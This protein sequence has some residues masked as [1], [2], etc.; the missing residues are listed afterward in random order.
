MRINTF[1][2]NRQLGQ[3]FLH[4][5]L[6]V[7]T[8]LA[9]IQ[10]RGT[11]HEIRH[12]QTSLN[13]SKSTVPMKRGANVDSRFG[14][15][16]KKD[17]LPR[18]QHIVKYHQRIHFI[19]AITQRIILDRPTT[20]EPGAAD[21]SNAWRPQIANKPNGII[22][23]RIVTPVGNRWLGKRLISVRGGGFIFGTTHHDTSISF[24]NHVQQH[25][26]ILFLRT[27]GAI[28]FGVGIGRHMK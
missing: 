27:F 2:I 11:D 28:S 3:F 26:R 17:V 7:E 16:I 19:K 5:L 13:K 8:G 6:L 24:T 9:N 15:T 23:Q 12:A 1:S 4:C 20:G 21:H 25:V 18:D 22:R 10:Q 14:M